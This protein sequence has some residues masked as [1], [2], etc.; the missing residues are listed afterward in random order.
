[1]HRIAVLAAGLLAASFAAGCVA[2]STPPVE[3]PDVES[4]DAFTYFIVT[5]PDTRR[6]AYPRCG[7]V[8]VKRVNRATTVCA[9]GMLAAECHV[10]DVDLDELGLNE[11]QDAR[12]QRAF[13]EKHALL[14]GRLTQRDGGFAVPVETLVAT[15]GWRGAA[16]SVATGRFSRLTDTGVRCVTS[17]CPTF[18]EQLLNTNLRQVVAEVDLTASGADERQVERGLEELGTSGILAAGSTFT[19][20]GPAGLAAGFR[21]SEFYLRVR[22]E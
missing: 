4:S 22:P 10:A 11:N 2:V 13:A 6:C 8:F 21:A 9:D 5:R 19:V 16:S 20:R 18:L 1:M 15:E 7:G 14:R 17:P 12:L 3:P